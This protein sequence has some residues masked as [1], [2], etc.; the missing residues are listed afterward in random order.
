MLQFIK[1][2]TRVRDHGTIPP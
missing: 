2:S 1:T